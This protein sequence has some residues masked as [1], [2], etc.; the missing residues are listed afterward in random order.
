MG[1]LWLMKVWIDICDVIVLLSFLVRSFTE[2]AIEEESGGLGLLY[3]MALKHTVHYLNFRR[4][5]SK[6]APL[7]P[8]CLYQIGSLLGRCYIK[9]RRGRR[10]TLTRS[11][12]TSHGLDSEKELR[13]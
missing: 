11:H 8:M 2:M 3:K 10:A 4:I 1:N 12:S 5:L 9:K 6:V 7:F 13:S